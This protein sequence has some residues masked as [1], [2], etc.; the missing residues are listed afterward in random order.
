MLFN[1]MVGNR[2]TGMS[3]GDKSPNDSSSMS[4]DS[5]QSKDHMSMFTNPSTASQNTGIA[6]GASNPASQPSQPSGQP[7]QPQANPT[8]GTLLGTSG[9]IWTPE[10]VQSYYDSRGVKANASSPQYWADKSKE[11]WAQKDPGFFQKFL[12]NAE[13]FSGGPEQT[14]MAMGWGASPT[15]QASGSMNAGSGQAGMMGMPQIQQMLQQ[16]LAQKGNGNPA[17][18]VSNGNLFANSPQATMDISSFLH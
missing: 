12:S 5:G 7:A 4:Y 17:Q 15:G 11:D 1:Q 8:D 18:Q 3:S 6:G 16:L 14:R 10:R 2:N 13:E 9:T